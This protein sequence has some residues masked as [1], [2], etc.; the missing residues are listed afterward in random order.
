MSLP[1]TTDVNGASCTTF[2]IVADSSRKDE[3]GKYIPIFYRVTAWRKLGERCSKFL[4]TKGE[5]IL[6]VGDFSQREYTD[7]AG[8][9]RNQNQIT[10]NTVEFLGGRKQVQEQAS[11]QADTD[12]LP[13]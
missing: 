7:D 6:V 3:N 5:S 8:Q 1:N 13:F 9:K 2:N 4:S 10:A 11:P 12:E